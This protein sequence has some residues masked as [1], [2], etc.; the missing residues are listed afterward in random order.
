VWN[1]RL[2][3]GLGRSTL[4]QGLQSG[5]LHVPWTSYRCSVKACDHSG[6]GEVGCF[7]QPLEKGLAGVI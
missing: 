2:S 5:L 1:V 6:G 3:A 7:E 4:A